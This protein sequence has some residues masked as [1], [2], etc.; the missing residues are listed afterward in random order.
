LLHTDSI[1]TSRSSLPTLP[2][3][4]QTTAAAPD[5]SSSTRQQQQQQQQQQQHHTATNVSSTRSH[6]QTRNN[7]LVITATM[8]Q[9]QTKKLAKAHKSKGSQKHKAV[10]AIQTLSKGRK[11]YNTKGIKAVHAKADQELSKDITKKNEALIAAKAVSAG[12]KFFLSDVASVGQTEFKKQLN[13][14]HKKENKAKKLT[15]RLKE[16]LRKINEGK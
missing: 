8:A 10:R 5:N 1:N 16:Q 3:Q 9:G 12:S 2:Q 15:D 11:H 7:P 6:S 13:E 14:R 4:H